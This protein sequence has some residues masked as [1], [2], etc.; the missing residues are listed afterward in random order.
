[1][2]FSK[3][4]TSECLICSSSFR[5]LPLYEM[6]GRGSAGAFFSRHHISSVIVPRTLPSYKIQINF[7]ASCPLSFFFE[8]WRSLRASLQTLFPALR[9]WWMGIEWLRKHIAN[10]ASGSKTRASFHCIDALWLDYLKP[11]IYIFHEE[12]HLVLM[13]ILHHERKEIYWHRS[14]P[15]QSCSLPSCNQL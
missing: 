9:G 4:N 3:E 12:L 11:L 2:I 7:Q 6:L 1:M 5:C 8:G 14:W 15:W 10:L 13:N